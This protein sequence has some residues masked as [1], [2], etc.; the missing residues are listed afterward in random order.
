MPNNRGLKLIFVEND[1]RRNRLDLEG[2][3]DWSKAGL[4]VNESIQVN[5]GKHNL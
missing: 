3:L 5:E 4:F 1:I 2:D